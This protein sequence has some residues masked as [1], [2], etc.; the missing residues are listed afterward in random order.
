MEH[1]RVH[2]SPQTTPRD[3]NARRERLPRAEIRG[4]DRDA[5]DE[6]TAAADSYAE[7]LRE[8]GL[9]VGCAEG[10]HEHSED[11]EEGPGE[12]EGAEVAGV[13]EGAGGDSDSEEEVG[14]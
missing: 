4:Y 1:N 14:L 9:V 3:R 13:V 11:D 8:D 6:E 10:C 2:H 5:G 12:G 7:G